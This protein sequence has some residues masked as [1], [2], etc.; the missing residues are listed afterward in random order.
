MEWQSYSYF[1]IRIWGANGGLVRR[2]N[3]RGGLLL[4]TLP[5]VDANTSVFTTFKR[6]GGGRWYI[7]LDS[8]RIGKSKALQA[9]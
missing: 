4:A 8:Y 2:L 9:H 5:H 6:E 7:N 1:A 3:A